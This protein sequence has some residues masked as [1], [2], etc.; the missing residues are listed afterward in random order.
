MSLHPT[1]FRAALAVEIRFHI[2]ALRRQGERSATIQHLR[3]L[4]RPPS[5]ALA[6]APSGPSADTRYTQ[7][8]REV[9]EQDREIRHFIHPSPL[10]PA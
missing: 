3:N 7:I 5:T 2:Q 9:C 10:S 8:F 1:P 6:G 4:V